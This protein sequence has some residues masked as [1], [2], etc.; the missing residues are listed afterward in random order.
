[1]IGME[2]GT[3]Q[4]IQ[5]LIAKDS[6]SW[7][8][9]Q[10]FIG[11]L[12]ASSNV[13]DRLGQALRQL[14]TE[15]PE[16]SGAAALK[17]G[18]VQYA[19][20]R[21]AEALA[22]LSDATDN[23]TRHYARAQCLRGLR[24]FDQALEELGLAHKQGMTGDEMGLEMIEVR[25]LAGEPEQAQQQ[26]AE[27]ADRMGETAQFLYIQGEI[28][29]LQ[30]LIEE[31]GDSYERAVDAGEDYKP[32]LFR[33]AYFYDLHG[34]EREAVELYQECVQHPPVH[35]NA[36]LNLAVLYEDAGR[37]DD[38]ILALRRILTLNPQHQRARLFLKDAEAS[39]TMYFDEDQAK[40]IARRNAVLDI[41]VT[42][43]ELSV[44]ARNCLK[45]MDIRTLG[46]LVQISESELLSYKNFGE[47]SL[48]EIKDML[49]AKGLRLGQ[50]LEEGSE[51][52]SYTSPSREE[53]ADE[54]LLNTPLS[55]IEFS[56]RAR[57]ALESLGVES[58]GD[59]AQKSEAELLT[60]K[61]FGQTSL[62][63]VKQRL[64]EYNLVLRNSQ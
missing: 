43:F 34:E 22:T 6:W 46:D 64:S 51:L 59:L 10:Q 21:L 33:L 53:G 31:A 58:L 4:A 14:Q 19:M 45:K 36:L 20:C 40:A 12:T 26:L 52:A 49:T 63:E 54:G 5:E 8:D 57:R 29:E 25:A 7:D 39:K 60:C 23:A 41:P 9:F 35:V 38:A 61:N 2:Q 47:T 48:K 62:N 17:I 27:Y 3:Q 24:R 32:A 50:A 44:R 13:P 30:G 28:L 11:Q 56:V 15:H 42:D 16:P 55:Q 1:M 18:L 37:Y